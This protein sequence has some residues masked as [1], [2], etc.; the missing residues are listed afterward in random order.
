MHT[1]LISH[2][3]YLF[4]GLYAFICCFTAIASAAHAIENEDLTKPLSIYYGDPKSSIVIDVKAK[5]DCIYCK[6]QHPTLLKFIRKHEVLVRYELFA[7]SL[8][9]MDSLLKCASENSKPGKSGQLLN[10]IWSLPK[11]SYDNIDVE[12]LLNS[13][14]LKNRKELITLCKE[15]DATLPDS[16]TATPWLSIMNLE[17]DARINAVGLQRGEDL[18]KL[19]KQVIEQ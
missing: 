7:S 8:K 9:S 18:D 4:A 15:Y 2:N 19:M 13:V 6:R 14:N 10:V 12:K 3:K 16:T 17:S 1:S 11:N 5:L